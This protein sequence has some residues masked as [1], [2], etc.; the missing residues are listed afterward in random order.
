MKFTLKKIRISPA[1]LIPLSFLTVIIVGTL[2]LYQ[3][4]CAAAGC[5]TDLLTALFTATT[6]VCVTGLVVVDT[7]AHWSF[8]GQLIILL[9][10]QLGGLGV[11]TVVFGFI[12]MTSKNISL[13][14]RMLLKDAMNMNDSRH[15]LR[16]LKRVI[17]GTFLVEGLGALFY[18]LD[19]IPRLGVKKGIWASIF[20]AVSAF[21]NAGMDVVGP[22]SMISLRKSPLLMI[23]TMVM[24]VLGGLGYVVWFDILRGIRNGIRKDFSPVQIFKRLPEHTK[25]VIRLT[26]ALVFGGA[27][28]FFILEYN[29]PETIGDMN[30]WNKMMNAFFQS[31]TLRTAGFASVPQEKLTGASCVAGCLWMFIGGSPIGTAGGVKTVTLCLVIMNAQSYIRCRNEIVVFNRRVSEELMRKATAIVTVSFMTVFVFTILLMATNPI[32]LE[33]AIYEVV[34]ASATVGLSRALTPNLNEVGRLI[35]ITAMYLGR[36]GPIS[37]AIFFSKNTSNM[38]KIHYTD[39]D[40]YVG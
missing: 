12:L 25:L 23:V 36:I 30:F 35:I 8:F 29:N 40:F 18:M 9:L 14:D 3:P 38:N 33:D 15:L 17:L 37:M 27:L 4:I 1:H 24:I 34:S 39:G 10:A 26:L 2:I 20:Q 32:S 7:Y 21:C 5:E 16:F 22:D 31:V 19:F 6:S 28:V 13:G 11:V